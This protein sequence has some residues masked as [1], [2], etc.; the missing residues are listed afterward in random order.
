MQY[1]EVCM[2]LQ[3]EAVIYLHH[4]Q[5]GHVSCSAACGCN[6]SVYTIRAQTWS[7]YTSK[8]PAFGPPWGSVNK[9]CDVV[10]VMQCGSSV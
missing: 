2:S 5:S 3:P 10:V 8:Q 6:S 7:A 9:A 4:L 1:V